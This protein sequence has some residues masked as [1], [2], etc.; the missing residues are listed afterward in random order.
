MIDLDRVENV[1]VRAPNWLGDV[2]MATPALRTLRSRCPNARIVVWVR[3]GL[4]PVLAGSLDIDEVRTLPKGDAPWR[5]LSRSVRQVHKA[6]PYDLGL[7][8]PDSFSSA[9]LMR[10]AGGRPLVGYANAARKLLLDHP[11]PVEVSGAEGR[12]APREDRIQGLLTSLGMPSHDFAPRLETTTV[13]EEKVE[14]L[15]GGKG[16]RETWIG[17]APGAAYGPSKCW[18][19]DR[20][21]ALGDALANQGARIF[22]LGAPGERDLCSAVSQQMTLPCMDLSGQLDL[23]AF[24]ALIRRLDLM[25]CNDSG[26]RHLAVGLQVPALVFFGPTDVW[27]TRRNLENVSVLEKKEVSCR[28]CYKRNCPTDHRCLLDL[29]V[30][31]ALEEARA[32]LATGWSDPKGLYEEAE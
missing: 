6:G 8:L 9:I 3:A 31:Q 12:R 15:L 29:T 21:A 26:A 27:R 23:G 11:V 18:P 30:A 28:P 2:V 25:I 10:F 16:H 13:E 20:Y 17:L 7:C 1:L 5:E 19:A 14:D 24:K 32:R 22:I 4:E